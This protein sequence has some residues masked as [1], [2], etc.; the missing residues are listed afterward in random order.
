MRNCTDYRR[1]GLTV[2]SSNETVTILRRQAEQPSE[3][4]DDFYGDD[5][6]A[7]ALWLAGDGDARRLPPRGDWPS[8]EALAPGPAS[9]AAA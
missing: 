6:Y 3:G 8:H 2:P 9:T 4:G 7:Q 5:F 1:L